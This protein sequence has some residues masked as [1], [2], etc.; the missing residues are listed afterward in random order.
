MS[1]RRFHSYLFDLDGT[2]L[3]S[4]ELIYQC[5]R[6]TAEVHLTNL[7]SDRVWREGFG[8]PLREQFRMVT[9]DSE[10]IEQMVITYRQMHLSHHDGAVKLYPQVLEV[11]KTL[12]AR[13]NMLGVVTS[14]LSM[15]AERGLK[16]TGL[17]DF[18]DVIVTADDVVCPK[19]NPEPVAL[20]LKRLS[21]IDE[22]A[23][24]VGDSP[25]DIASGN[26]AGIA[27]AVALWGPFVR[28]DFQSFSP[29]FFLDSPKEILLL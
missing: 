15:G 11:I 2:L 29:T 12:S 16:L 24:F 1:R 9:S 19:P 7:P 28:T 13:G 27:T 5:F 3:D 14:K 25:H 21:A 6:H 8:R 22:S 10:L 17:F 4:I 20:C 26:A 23:V 18:F